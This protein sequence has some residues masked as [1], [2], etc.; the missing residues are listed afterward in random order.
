MRALK[1]GRRPPTKLGMLDNDALALCV[2]CLA[3]AAIAARS[4]IDLRLTAVALARDLT[5]A[6]WTVDDATELL[7]AA[8]AGAIAF[9]DASALDR[10]AFAAALR[11]LAALR[12][13]VRGE[14]VR[15]GEDDLEAVAGT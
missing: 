6:G 7:D 4:P 8:C 15:L 3:D 2:E 12:A 1:A 13:D 14:L 11:G 10:D 9:V 5:D